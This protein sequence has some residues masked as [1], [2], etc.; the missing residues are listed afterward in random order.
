M[1]RAGEQ[2]GR[3]RRA[4]GGRRE[5]AAGAAQRGRRHAGARRRGG[6]P[7]ACAAGGV[8]ALGAPRGEAVPGAAGAASVGVA[9]HRDDAHEDLVL[10]RRRRLAAGSNRSAEAVAWREDPR[11]QRAWWVAGGA[12][13]LLMVLTVIDMMSVDNV[14][15][16]AVRP[17]PC[18]LYIQAN[19]GRTFC[20]A[21]V[22][23]DVAPRA[24]RFGS[25]CFTSTYSWH[26]HSRKRKL[27][28]LSYGPTN[29]VLHKLAPILS[30]SAGVGGLF[31]SSRRCC[32]I[33]APEASITSHY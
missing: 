13:V 31:A 1:L 16:V 33:Q 9:D 4:A 5:G 23:C 27:S 19:S 22:R 30:C 11:K 3:Q 32:P 2:G 26:V 20:W 12:G 14:Y 28:Y 10:L 29:T 25:P 17:C 15:V 7:A 18:C 21:G 24:T 8:A 6:G